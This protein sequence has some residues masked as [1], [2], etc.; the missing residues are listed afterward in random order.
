M[1]HCVQRSRHNAFRWGGCPRVHRGV[2]Y[3]HQHRLLRPPGMP[4]RGGQP[5]HSLARSPLAWM[6]LQRPSQSPRVPTH[7]ART[8]SP[9]ARWGRGRVIWPR[10]SGRCSRRARSAAWS[11]KPV[12]A[13]RGARGPCGNQA[14]SAGAS[15][16]PGCLKRR[17]T[18]AQPPGVLPGH[19]PGA[20][21]Q[22]LA[23]PAPSPPS[24]RPRCAT[25]AGRGKRP[26]GLCRPPRDG[27]QPAGSAL[28]AVR[29]GE[30]PGA[31]RPGA[32][33]ARGAVRPPRSPWSVQQ[34]ARP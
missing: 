20:C 15:P 25:C 32:G 2:A 9:L 26:C 21:G 23:P 7:T 6:S 3:R 1:Q 19:G 5:W 16:P 17:G 18:E 22:G 24:T 34:T 4:R 28:L 8:A 30:P 29:R 31:R 33:A 27:A 11:T 13:A 10:A 12:P 14:P